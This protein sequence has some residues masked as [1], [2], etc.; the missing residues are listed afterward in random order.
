MFAAIPPGLIEKPSE[1]VD[2]LERVSNSWMSR[3]VWFAVHESLR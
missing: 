3:I 1:K 2:D